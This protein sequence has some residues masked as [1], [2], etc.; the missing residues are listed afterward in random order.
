MLTLPVEGTE[1]NP[2]S[3]AGDPMPFGIL[4]HQG[5]KATPR[6]WVPVWWLSAPMER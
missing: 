3:T 2:K 6:S 1:L 5:P 4:H